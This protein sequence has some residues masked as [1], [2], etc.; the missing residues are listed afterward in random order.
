MSGQAIVAGYAAS[1]GGS[2]VTA[3]GAFSAFSCA[4]I[5]FPNHS[6]EQSSS[7]KQPNR[8][9]SR[10]INNY[11]RLRSRVSRCGFDW[12]GDARRR[13]V[14]L[15]HDAETACVLIFMLGD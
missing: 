15:R 8:F 11:S 12:L 1:G 10:M 7:T 3:A 14:V 2:E 13:G 4:W 9:M 6:T 5:L